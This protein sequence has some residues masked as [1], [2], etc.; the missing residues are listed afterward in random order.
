M[1]KLLELE[2]TDIVKYTFEYVFSVPKFKRKY[3]F[4]HPKQNYTLGDI[5]RHLLKILKTGVSYRDYET[6]TYVPKSSINDHNLFFSR[7]EIFKH[8]YIMLLKKYIEN[9]STL[10]FKYQK[11]D[12]TFFANMNGCEEIS[13]NKY[14][15]NKNGL[16]VSLLTTSN[17]IPYSVLVVSGSKNDGKIVEDHFNNLFVDNQ[18]YLY[19]NANRYKHYLLA[20]KMYDTKE[21]RKIAET[22]SITCIIDYNVRNTKDPAKIKKFT[23]AQ[24]E[25][26]KKRIGIENLNSWIKKNKRLRMVEEKTKKAF[27]SFIYLS[28][29]KIIVK[30]IQ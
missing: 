12:T 1:E 4:T 24:E 20:D 5:V 22:N 15:K 8:T 2:T 11:I 3:D 17:N 25:I 30:R 28:L 29:I 26:Y 21:V 18:S 7:N 10:E 14:Y 16:K 27:E 6:L 13:R 9:L 19:K 23:K